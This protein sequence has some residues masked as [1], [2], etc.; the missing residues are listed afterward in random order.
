MNKFEKAIKQ[1]ALLEFALGNGEYYLRD[2]E[3]DE[4]WVLGSWI[5]YILPYCKDNNCSAPVREMFQALIKDSILSQQSKLD[6]LLYHIYVFYYLT[7]EKRLNS[8]DL[9]KDLEST[10][11]IEIDAVKAIFIAKN[12]LGKLNELK[13][14]VSLIKSRG[15]LNSYSFE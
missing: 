6:V 8:K 2:R 5:N 1:N 4:H 13:S 11:G 9:I 14:T 12:N 3:H 7:E 15:G 10:V